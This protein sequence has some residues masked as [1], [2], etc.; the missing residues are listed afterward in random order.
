LIGLIVDISA[1]DK[2]LEEAK[3]QIGK[4]LDEAKKQIEEELDDRD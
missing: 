2:V 4:G 3:E 1:I